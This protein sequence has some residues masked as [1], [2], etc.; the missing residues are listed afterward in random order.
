MQ[1]YRSLPLETIHPSSSPAQA[2]RRLYFNREAMEELADTIKSDG[3]HQPIVVR[4]WRNEIVRGEAFE[5]VAGERRWRA[6]KM[7]GLKEIP[8]RVRELSDEQASREFAAQ[9]RELS[10]PGSH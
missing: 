2:E 9:I 6:A 4:P 1:E 5:L 8:A 10:T 7:A 3:V